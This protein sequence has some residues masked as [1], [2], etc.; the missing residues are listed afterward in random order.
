MQVLDGLDEMRLA[1]DEI[2]LGRLFDGDGIEFHLLL[3]PQ[4]TQIV[5]RRNPP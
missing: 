5:T 3:H 4:I 2:H 1:E